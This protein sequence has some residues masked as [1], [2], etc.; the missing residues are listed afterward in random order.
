[1]VTVVLKEET[2]K[3]E[4]SPGRTCDG[5]EEDAGEV[6]FGTIFV[7]ELYKTEV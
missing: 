2:Q 6:P 4:R 7:G 3:K 5:A 1:M